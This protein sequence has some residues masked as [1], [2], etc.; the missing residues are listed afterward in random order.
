MCEECFIIW[1]DSAPPDGDTHWNSET[2]GN[3]S[4]RRQRLCLYPYKGNVG[5]QKFEPDGVD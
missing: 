3:E 5:V 2:L 4:R 1:Y